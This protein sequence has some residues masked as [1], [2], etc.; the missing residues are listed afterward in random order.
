MVRLVQSLTLF[1]TPPKH[2]DIPTQS[3]F[4]GAAPPRD[5]PLSLV[6]E[7][8][9]RR[10]FRCVV[11]EPDPIGRIRVRRWGWSSDRLGREPKCHWI[12][13]Y[14]TSGKKW[15]SLEMKYFSPQLVRPKFLL[16]IVSVRT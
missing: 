11:P 4:S 13:C 7:Q 16:K 2:H 12:A 3:M 15:A 8:T 5:V 14:H 6:P 9:E 10:I 1:Y